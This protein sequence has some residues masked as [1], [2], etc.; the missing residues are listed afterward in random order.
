M[1]VY[2]LGIIIGPLPNKK[3]KKENPKQRTNLYLMRQTIKLLGTKVKRLTEWRRERDRERG[4]GEW[5]PWI[6]PP[7]YSFISFHRAT[8]ILLL[9]LQLVIPLPGPGSSPP[10]LSPPFPPR[11]LGP[12]S[13]P[14]LILFLMV[15]WSVPLSQRPPLSQSAGLHSLL[16]LMSTNR[17]T[18]H[19]R[20]KVDFPH[21]PPQP[22]SLLL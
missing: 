5:D 12:V 22:N 11:A 3:G 1:V 17:P 8:T 13:S 19:L 18:H 16:C 21:K 10:L 2:T 9:L 4:R 7:L 20:R 15:S 6:P 14:R